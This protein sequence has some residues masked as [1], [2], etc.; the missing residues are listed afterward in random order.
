MKEIKISVR[1]LVEFLFRS[2][3]LDNR[4]H[5]A[6]DTA[7]QEGGRIHRMIQKRMGSDYQAEVPLSYTHTDTNYIL[8][9]DGRADGVM[10]RKDKPLL[11]DEIKG[12]YRDLKKIKEPDYVHLAQARCY[13]AI[14]T[15]QNELEKVS[16]R[17]TYCNIESEEIKLFEEDHTAAEII[18]WFENT[19]SLYHRWAEYLA[20][21]DEVRKKSI[22]GAQFPFP[23]REGQK[24]LAASVYRT[25][26][27]G[28]K[29]FLEAP[30]GTGK[31]IS[32]VFPAVKAIGEDKA[33]RIFYLTAKTITRTVAEETFEILRR[34]Q[35]LKFK[36]VT[37][38]AKDKICFIEKSDCN[39]AACLYAEGHF[40]RINDCIYEVLT[41]ADSFDRQTIEHY[42][43]KHSVC[44]FELSLDLSLFADAIICDY[45]YVFDPFIYLK[46]FF[47]AGN[48]GENI[49]L[50][51]EAHNLL[52]RGRDMY[53]KA[54]N[55]EVL[56]AF[57][58]LIKAVHPR[59]ANIVA[60]ICTE[61]E[62]Y[63]DECETAIVLDDISPLIKKINLI[64]NVISSWL[65]DHTE[66]MYRD[67]ILEF[68][69]DISGFA[70]IYELINEKYV[71]FAENDEENG[72]RIKLLC[73]DPSDNLSLCMERA[74]STILFSATLLPIQY[75]KKLLGG[76]SED[77]EI[78]A[79]SVFDPSRCGRLIASDVTSKYTRR[80]ENEYRK[81]A[82]YIDAIVSAKSGN[83][84]IFFP[85][86][87]FMDEVGYI[88]EQEYYDEN[89]QEILV[90][91]E[92]MSE[93]EREEFLSRFSPANDIDL[94]SII[95]MEIEVEPSKSILGFCMMGGIF[96]EGI[97]LKDDSLIGVIIVGTGI[98]L[99]CNEREII[100]EFFELSDE[101]G[102]DYAYRY[103]G[104]NKVLQAAGR[105]IRTE[106]DAGIVALLDERFLQRSYY[107]MFPREWKG[108]IRTSTS[109]VKNDVKALWKRI[110]AK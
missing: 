73:A 101:D 17:I 5:H 98:P 13:A 87:V 30:T 106:T 83:Y 72:F 91:Q 59:I 53:S 1:A 105:V 36:T 94:E 102:F 42:A 41:K 61:M 20:T 35:G 8:T 10:E 74:K 109:R 69:F 63:R 92:I 3:N 23:Y 54:I 39:P 64:I 49:F 14:L 80:S 34:E 44:P 65:E 70:T 32:T 4:I 78:Y 66:G 104:M 18:E 19:L 27:H 55:L 40:D 33:D 60:S 82:A 28:R 51:D 68:Y 62:K 16:V 89:T 95:N 25:I 38:T 24:D 7:M 71:I 11:V 93:E 37:L 9:I 110:E 81:I 76:T 52:D 79:H 107:E 99:V 48:K 108:I 96:G 6:P 100:K 85:S 58:S 57:E 45:N 97:D 12:T 22:Q 15:M 84:M 88:F 2:G 31:T 67:E 43:K 50:I 26:Y 75:Y 29:L 21:W 86:R 47:A 56:R 103:P 46:R 90:Q 77:Y